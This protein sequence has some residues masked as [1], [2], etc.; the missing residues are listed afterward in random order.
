MIPLL[1]LGSGDTALVIAPHPDDETLGAGGTINRLARSGV[2]VHVLAVV[3]VTAPM[4]DGYSDAVLRTKEF[5]AACDALGVKTRTVAWTSEADDDRAFAPGRHLRDLTALIESGS[6]LS[7]AR[8]NPDLLLIPAATGFHQD[9]QAVHLAAYAAARPGVSKPT[10]RLVL[11]FAGPEDGWTTRSEPWRMHVDTTANW[12]AKQ[13]ALSAYSSQLREP[14]HPRSITAVRAL[15][16]AAGVAAGTELAE[17]F[18]PYR[19]GY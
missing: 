5:D 17:R 7:L 2:G 16:V 13:A 14:P 12:P 4:W 15:D 6:D 19:I 3:C 18:V 8:L 11:G 9:H 10:P 1:G